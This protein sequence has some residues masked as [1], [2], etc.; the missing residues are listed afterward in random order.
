MPDA[1][2]TH[3]SV[4]GNGVFHLYTNSTDMAFAPSLPCRDLEHGCVLDSA[5][6]ARGIGHKYLQFEHGGHGF[7]ADSAKA[8]AEAIVWKKEFLNWLKDVQIR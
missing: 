7:G 4:D 6:T 1:V 5:L 8:G 3:L 2:Y